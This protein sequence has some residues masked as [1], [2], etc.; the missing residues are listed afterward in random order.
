[1]NYIDWIFSMLASLIHEVNPTWSW[2]ILFICFDITGFAL[3]VFCKG[4]LHLCSWGILLCKASIYLSGFA[5]RVMPASSNQCG[6]VS[7]S[8]VFWKSVYWVVFLP[9]TFN[10]NYWWSLT[11][12]GVLIYLI[13][14][15]DMRL[16]RL[17]LS[18]CACFGKLWFSKNVSTSYQAYWYEALKALL[19]SVGSVVLVSLSVLTPR[20]SFLFFSLS[21]LPVIYQFY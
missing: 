13:Y 5:V 3:L 6:D 21:V 14:L 19:M 11:G 10:R 18:S 7:L 15:L 4:F 17:S 8:S 9:K 2:S 16:C 20:L 12:L 1:M